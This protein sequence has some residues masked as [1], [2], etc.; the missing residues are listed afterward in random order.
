[1]TPDAFS[2]IDGEPVIGH[3]A[4]FYSIT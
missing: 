4:G 2:E 1:M 3:A